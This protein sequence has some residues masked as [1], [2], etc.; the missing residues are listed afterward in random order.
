MEEFTLHSDEENFRFFLYFPASADEGFLSGCFPRYLSATTASFSE[1]DDEIF[2]LVTI[3]LARFPI[4]KS[5]SVEKYS[6]S[7]KY[8]IHN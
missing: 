1:T 2:S 7:G 3:L 4:V 8:L 5:N 6:K